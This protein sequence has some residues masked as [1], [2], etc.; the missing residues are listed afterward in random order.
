MVYT[1]E[2]GMVLE[3]PSD[4]SRRECLWLL[5]E[6]LR[7]RGAAQELPRE[8]RDALYAKVLDEVGG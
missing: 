7:A 3:V 1:S 2:G 8:Q 4:A 6:A 5:G